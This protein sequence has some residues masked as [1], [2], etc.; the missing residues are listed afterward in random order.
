MTKEF[1]HIRA[2]VTSVQLISGYRW[3]RAGDWTLNSAG[4]RS[5][6]KLRDVIMYDDSG[7]KWTLAMGWGW[8]LSSHSPNKVEKKK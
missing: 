6:H 1:R 4:Y 2:I 3:G 8:F 7:G 5:R